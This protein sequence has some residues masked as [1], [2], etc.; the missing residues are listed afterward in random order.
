MLAMFNFALYISSFN[1]SLKILFMSFIFLQ[2]CTCVTFRLSVLLEPR[3]E[4]T[5]FLYMR[6]QRRRPASR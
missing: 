6:N 2:L 3:H 1:L 4:K 5:G